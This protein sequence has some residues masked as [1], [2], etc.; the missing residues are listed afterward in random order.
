LG[1]LRQ[2]SNYLREAL[3][4]YDQAD[5]PYDR[6]TIHDALGQNLLFSGNLTGAQIHLERALALWESINSPSPIA[7]TLN[8]LGFIH[9]CRGEHK[10]ALEAH[11]RV[12][13]EARRSGDLRVEA[14]ALACVG[15][16]RRDTGDLDGALA[17]YAESQSLAEQ[18]GDAQLTGYLLDA[19]GETYRRRGDY[20]QALPLAR[21]AYEWAQEHSATLDLGRCA[22]TL[23]AISYEQ[24]RTSLAL[25]YLDQACELLQVS[26]ANR[27]LAVAY[28]HRAQAYYQAARKQDALAELERIVDCL[29]QLGYDAFLVPLISQMRPVIAYAV[30][31]GAGGRLLSDLLDKVEQADQELSDTTQATLVEPEPSL[32]IYGLGRARVVV[33]E[34]TLTSKDWRSITSRDLFFYLLSEGP[35][36]KNEL[37]TYFWPD[38]APGKLRST[39]HITIY[40]LRRAL[41]PLETVV[42]EDDRY[43]FNRR[44]NYSFDVETFESLLTHAETLATTSPARTIELFSQ[45]VDLY[46]GDFLEDYRSPHDE[47]RVLK[48]N[49]L[50]EKYQAALERLGDLLI[51]ENEDQAALDVFKRAVS[52]DPYRESARRGVMRSLAGLKRRS[53]ALYCYNEWERFIRAEFGTAPA[54][55]TERLYQRI[56]ANEPLD[57]DGLNPT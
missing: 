38:L 10:E 47:W 13:H 51:N 21:R 11:K 6:A 57:W 46:R 53:E 36:T 56:L 19:I 37:A 33:G 1:D 17:A 8:N 52:Y 27:E 26:Q 40:R 3:R 39:F 50:S 14:Y 20:S 30:A 12:L 54:P 44:L 4:R 22:T 35:A 24:G 9:S 49:E 29:L 28:L 16:I 25:R 55:E 45:A 41:D 31:E 7:V 18:I 48:A 2:G 32:H 5:S 43:H 15:D 34:R 42:F 23:G